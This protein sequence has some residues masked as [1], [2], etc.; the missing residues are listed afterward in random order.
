M[1]D[2]LLEYRKQLEPLREA[3]READSLGRA[4]PQEDEERLRRRL[5]QG[6]STLGRLIKDGQAGKVPLEESD[7]EEAKK[8]RSEVKSH[9]TKLRNRI[10]KRKQLGAA[11]TAA[12]AEASDEGSVAEP[13][14][15]VAAPPRFLLLMR[16]PLM[17]LPL[18]SRAALP[19][20]RGRRRGRAEA[21]GGRRGGLLRAL[22]PPAQAPRGFRV[23]GG[24]EQAHGA[25]PDLP[26]PQGGP[27]ALGPPPGPQL[28]GQAY[29]GPQGD[30]AS[31]RAASIRGADL[32]ADLG[33]ASQEARGPA[34]AP[35]A[36]EGPLTAGAGS[37][38]APGSPSGCRSWRRP[39]APLPRPPIE[40]ILIDSGSMKDVPLVSGMR[41]TRE[42]VGENELSELVLH[43][44][45][46]RHVAGVACFQLV[47]QAL[48][49]LILGSGGD[50]LHA[51]LYTRILSRT[52]KPWKKAITLGRT[53]APSIFAAQNRAKPCIF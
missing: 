10:N 46:R 35:P 22:G 44:V 26:R 17:R 13:A 34:E 8:L 6:S 9:R 23:R 45:L 38:G 33:G 48:H 28:P 19:R 51:C 18:L 21:Q 31:G 12:A 14:A 53:C 1:A 52:A 49:Q 29:T 41:Q 3:L 20:M 24:L 50:Y 2:A 42:V 36:S 39:R 32:G 7:L 15:A 4:A 43:V 25:R 30:S 37:P 16:Q 11:G 27:H 40:S 47:V 5:K